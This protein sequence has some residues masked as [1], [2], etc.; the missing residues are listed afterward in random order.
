MQMIQEEKG[1]ALLMGSEKMY[2]LLNMTTLSREYQPG[3]GAGGVSGARG[4][5]AALAIA[6]CGDAC[7]WK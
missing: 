7:R 6:S 3:G 5:S 4:L 1:L 2:G